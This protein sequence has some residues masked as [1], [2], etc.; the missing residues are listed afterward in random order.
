MTIDEGLAK[1][2]QMPTRDFTQNPLTQP[3]VTACIET[4]LNEVNDPT[5][6]EELAQ[7]YIKIIEFLKTKVLYN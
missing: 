3:E 1:I 4:L 7:F 6:D 5:L 2:L